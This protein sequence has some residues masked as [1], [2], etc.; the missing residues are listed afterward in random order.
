MDSR[1]WLIIGLIIFAVSGCTETTLAVYAR[2]N[3]PTAVKFIENTIDGAV[4]LFTGQ[5]NQSTTKPNTRLITKPNTQL[6]TKP[7][8]QLIAKPNTQLITKP[9]TQLITKP[10]TQLITKPNTQLVTKPNTQSI[11]IEER[12]QLCEYSTTDFGKNWETKPF[13]K[14]V[15]EAKEKGLTLADCAR[16]LCK[17]GVNPPSPCNY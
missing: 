13:L 11:R 8:T 15:Q 9:N 12:Y 3:A 1:H 6:I 16:I 4:N 5:K 2:E 17:T 14:W 10:N 7:N